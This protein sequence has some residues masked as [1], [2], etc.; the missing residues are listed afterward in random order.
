VGVRWDKFFDADTVKSSG[1]HSP[2]PLI[3]WGI[4][5]YCQLLVGAFTHRPTAATVTEESGRRRCRLRGT[6]LSGIPGVGSPTTGISMPGLRG[7]I[8][9][10][11]PR[12]TRP[13]R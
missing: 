3:T 10:S 5:P 7:P 11:P 13:Q 4:R 2:N 12:P 9:A 8:A 6:T 1:D